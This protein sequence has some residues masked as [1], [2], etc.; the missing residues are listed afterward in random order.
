M[1]GAKLKSSQIRNRAESLQSMSHEG[2]DGAEPGQWATRL[3]LL[4]EQGLLHAGPIAGRYRC[5]RRAEENAPEFP[6]TQDE[7]C[8]VQFESC[9]SSYPTRRLD[10]GTLSIPLQCV[11]P[12]QKS[13][14]NGLHVLGDT[15]TPGRD[16]PPYQNHV[17]RK[18]HIAGAPD[19]AAE[20]HC[21]SRPL[22]HCTDIRSLILAF[23]DPG[24]APETSLGEGTVVVVWRF[25]VAEGF[26]TRGHVAPLAN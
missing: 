10:E 4:H 18:S 6:F 17:L 7:Y 8:V 16:C 5:Y 3:R 22:P 23:E 20:S 26:Q 25:N 24:E 2:K 21:A 9:V 19:C 12:P 11:A 15:T 14:L 13:R 1:Q